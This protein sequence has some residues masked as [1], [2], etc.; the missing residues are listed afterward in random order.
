MHVLPH[1]CCTATVQL[2][3]AQSGNIRTLHRPVLGLAQHNRQVYWDAVLKSRLAAC[4]PASEQCCGPLDSALPGG[5]RACSGPAL[6]STT[7][8]A[9]RPQLPPVVPPP[10]L[11]L[12]TPPCAVLGG[13]CAVGPPP[14]AVREA[15]SA[16]CCSMT[17]CT[18]AACRARH[19]AR[20]TLHD[21]TLAARASG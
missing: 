14:P 21:A 18:V 2:I 17:A 8:S 4:M 11:P 10:E 13:G 1:R 6:P 16:C 15:C 12:S 20:S 3:H 9:G 5:R 7:Q 19:H